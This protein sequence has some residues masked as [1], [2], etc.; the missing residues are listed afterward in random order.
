MDIWKNQK[1]TCPFENQSHMVVPKM[2]Q[3]ALRMSLFSVNWSLTRA[4]KSAS[5]KK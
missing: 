4:R 3:P 5:H 1:L 2:H